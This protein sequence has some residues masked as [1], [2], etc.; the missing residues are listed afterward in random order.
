M[1]KTFNIT[2]LFIVMFSN[3]FYGQN[4]VA[5]KASLSGTVTDYHNKTILE[6]ATIVVLELNKT[7]YSDSTGKFQL[8]EI[9]PGS[10]TVSV[11]HPEC[12]TVTVD[13]TIDGPTSL[14]LTLEHH[15]EELDEVKVIGQA[16]REKTNTASEQRLNTTVLESYSTAT[17]GEALRELPGV[18]SLNTGAAITKP[19]I[20]GLSGSRILV[21]NDGVRMQDMEW[22]DEHAPNIDINSNGSVSVVKGAAALQYG[23]DAIGGTIVLE[24]QRI[25]PKDTLY[26]KTLLNGVS[27]GRG[28][29]MTTEITKIYDNGWFFKPQVSYK[30]LGDQETPDYVLS[31]TGVQENGASIHVGKNLF[32]WGWD[33]RYSYY[34]AE[35]AILRASH[36]GST[37]DL[38]RAI[39][40]GEPEV[41]R[42]F[43]YDL[44]NPRQKVTHHLGK[45]RFYKRFEG[46]GKL[47]LQYD[48]Q[49]N[50]R[51]E[52]DV[53]RGDNDD[54]ASIDLELTTHTF[55]GDFKWDSK[56]NFQLQTG[57]LARY[58][59]NFPNPNTGVRR[60]IPDYERF[61]AG[62]FLLGEYRYNNF[63][64]EGGIR[65]DFMRIDAQKFYRIT[66]W[67]NEGYDEE[68]SDL[69][70]DAQD[71]QFLVNPVFD[72][73]TVSGTVG[74]RW[75]TLNSGTL[76]ANYALA[77]RAPN[78]SEL[79]SDGL[80]H[81]AARIELGDLRI[82]KETS[83]KISVSYQ[84]NF[85]SWGFT[86]EPYANFV[87][88]FILIEPTDVEFTI[89]GS[90]PV[91]EYR[92][93]DVRLLGFDLSV[94]TDW[95]KNWST[96]HTFSFIKGRDISLEIPLINVPP[97]S[98][99][100]SVTFNKPEWNDFEVSLESQYVFRQNE[101]PD[102]IEV[103][104]PQDQAD[105]V[106]QVNTAPPAYHLMGLR[107]KLE[108]P[109]GN[110]TILT[111]SLRVNNLL[112]TSYRDYLNRLRYF[113]DDLGRNFILQL[114]LSY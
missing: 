100:N 24:P 102:D 67:E 62:L 23:G 86:I 112:N 88:D 99:N 35:I 107:S 10:Y 19:I 15:L 11:A 27:N 74:A 34:D 57:L 39:N 8:N 4:T 14:D 29:S 36:I 54:R 85:R 25:F 41:I 101:T 53:R 98:F 103:F 37:D 65:F 38:N 94:Y 46:L 92:Q 16:A 76:K 56:P 52:F 83:H 110:K 84:R 40:N 60:L 96:N 111:T 114:K 33:A 49:Q 87:Q 44:L 109:L 17:L 3:A 90:F 71:S 108:F 42:P 32:T 18:S 2:V 104:S 75:E 6:K 61:D 5:C 59:E 58:Q 31:N 28:G 68:F 26:G 48:F 81:S 1:L 105:I 7:T 106:L 64:F 43:T 22:G 30:R 13:V 20:H 113:A 51:L 77:Q 47:T 69:I 79:F 70:I 89:R 21:L 91:W 12:N 50:R 63:T 55:N 93:T 80:H 9:C 78:P 95:A 97:V 82:D 73:H 45:L 72:Y 66:R